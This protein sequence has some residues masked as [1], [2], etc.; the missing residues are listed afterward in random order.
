[1]S[2]LRAALL[3]VSLAA[4]AGASAQQMYKTVGPDGK[5]TFSDR[6]KLESAAQLSVMKSY[7]LRPVKPVGEPAATAE[8][9]GSRPPAIRAPEG[10]GVMTPQIEA[11]MLDVMAQAEFSRRYYPFCNA[12]QASARAFNL[13]GSGWKE[14]NFLALE[15]QRKLLM[16]V[17]SPAK[18][19]ELQSKLTAMMS[20]ETAKVSARSPDERA[21]WCK[22]A[23]AMMNNVEADISQP[24][25]MAVAIKPYKK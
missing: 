11:A 22:E 3:I 13:A 6:P 18:R 25:M 23:I 9:A 16:Q 8:S 5:V 20:E 10:T 17:V 15:Q 2:S 14:R 4:C 24:E 19:A 12:T 21:Q 7:T 1:M